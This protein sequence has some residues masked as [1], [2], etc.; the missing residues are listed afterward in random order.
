MDLIV[1]CCV[2]LNLRFAHAYN[3]VSS[4]LFASELGKTKESPQQIG[5]LAHPI[6]GQCK[7][8]HAKIHIGGNPLPEV[9]DV[10]GD[11]D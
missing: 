9:G 11:K 4:C 3:F 1:A 5:Y 10:D 7:T 2:E 6:I 8:G